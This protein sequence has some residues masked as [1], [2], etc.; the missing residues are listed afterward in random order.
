MVRKT[1]DEEGLLD[2]DWVVLPACN[3][4]TASP[5]LVLMARAAAALHV[6]EH[7]VARLEGR[8]RAQGRR[9]HRSLTRIARQGSRGN[10]AGPPR[11]LSAI[12]PREMS[13]PHH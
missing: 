11:R 6:P 13:C 4:A 9:E 2:A 5:K 1:A 10:S 3:T 8:D 7:H 12:Q